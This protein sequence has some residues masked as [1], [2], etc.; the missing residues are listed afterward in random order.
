MSPTSD[1]P[2]DDEPY[3]PTPMV[4]LDKVPRLLP[5]SVLFHHLLPYAPIEVLRLRPGF[6]QLAKRDVPVPPWSLPLE[7]WHAVSIPL[8]WAFLDVDDQKDRAALVTIKE[9]I[10]SRKCQEE[11]NR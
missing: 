10:D 7:H 2:S 5:W 9:E 3:V 4:T 11:P 8:A 6:E 1:L